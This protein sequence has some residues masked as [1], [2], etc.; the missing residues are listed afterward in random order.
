MT[1]AGL[2]LRCTGLPPRQ[3][4]A[5]LACCLSA[6]AV[7]A[8][9][10]G[11]SLAASAQVSI[12]E[13]YVETR[14]GAAESNGGQFVTR[15]SPSLSLSGHTGR[16]Q[17]SLYYAMNAPYQYSA[18]GHYR[19]EQGNT[20]TVQ[21]TLSANLVAEAVKGWLFVDARATVTEQPL[22]AYGLQTLPDSAQANANKAPVGTADISPYVRGTLVGTVDYELRLN[23][24]VHEVKGTSDSDT[25]T[26]G[27][28]VRL[29]SALRGTRLSWAIDLKQENIEYKLGRKTFHDSATLSLTYAPSADLQFS[30]NGGQEAT[31]VV[32]LEHQRYDIW[33]AGMRWT[34]TDRTSIRV[35][36]DK[37]YYGSSHLLAFEHRM[38]RSSITYTDSLES[39]NGGGGNSSSTSG[40]PVTLYELLFAQAAATEP[41]PILREQKVREL[42]RQMGRD[43]AETIGSGTLNSAV[44]LQRRQD[45]SLA[46]RGVRNT[47]NLQ[48]FVN[49][50]RLLDNPNGA[51]DAGV[52]RLHGYSASLSHQLTPVSSLALT[53]RRSVTDAN[54]NLAGNELKAV[55][56]GWTATPSRRINT[57]LSAQYVVFNST[58]RPYRE[59]SVTATLGLRF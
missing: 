20:L 26:L 42:L 27:G 4:L 45:L 39:T 21:N 59:T 52:T 6:T 40:R 2:R 55:T 51:P 9:E 17:G 47:L 22:S 46:W 12:S 16:V 24:G 41:D 28:K 11:R 58:T 37:R 32:Q 33:G 38:R 49:D 10:A 15:V 54:A 13:S 57:A 43:P 18:S 34:P 53:G 8:Q 1:T 56:L 31:D 50:S 48:A 3:G 35:Q 7:W 44:S 23:A 19:P 36:G 29:S 25:T 5:A 30:V 14:S